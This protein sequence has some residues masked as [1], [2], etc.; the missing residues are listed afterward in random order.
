MVFAASLLNGFLRTAK[1]NYSKFQTVD[2]RTV[3]MRGGGSAVV[4]VVLGNNNQQQ[5]QAPAVIICILVRI[6]IVYRV[7]HQ[8]CFIPIHSLNN[9]FFKF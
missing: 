3:I 8:K 6:L 4:S 2:C 1:F 5:L 9:K 7:I